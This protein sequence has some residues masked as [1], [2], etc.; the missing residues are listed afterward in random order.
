MPW[1]LISVEVTGERVDS[2]S[3]IFNSMGALSVT[4]LD[5]GDEP[6]LEPAPVETPLWSRSRLVALFE[7]GEDLAA[8]EQQLKSIFPAPHTDIHIESLADRD[9]STTWRYTLLLIQRR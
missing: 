9:W 8:V 2:V 7:E 4:V 6:L 1:L 5:A 3:E